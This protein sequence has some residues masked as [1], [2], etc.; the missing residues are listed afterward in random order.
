MST[1]VQRSPWARGRALGG[2]SLVNAMMVSRCSPHDYQ[3]WKERGNQGWG[4]DDVLPYFKKLETVTKEDW[5]HSGQSKVKGQ[6]KG[7]KIRH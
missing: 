7:K 4:Y 1:H 2:S 6:M 5:K 3:L